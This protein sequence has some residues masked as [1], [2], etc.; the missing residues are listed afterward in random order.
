MNSSVRRSPRVET[1]GGGQG[2]GKGRR[3]GSERVAIAP[4]YRAALAARHSLLQ[5][6]SF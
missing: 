4:V 5:Y 6:V 2:G 1:S 3:G